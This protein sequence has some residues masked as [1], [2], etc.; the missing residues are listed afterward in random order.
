[1]HHTVLRRVRQDRGFTQ[2]ELAALLRRTQAS[3]AYYESG[4][5]RPDR[6]TRELLGKI[7]GRD[8]VELLAL[9][10]KNGADPK[11][12]AAQTTDSRQEVVR[13]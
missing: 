7:L 5:R 1:M 9:D 2:V 3:I 13:V 11:A 12:D 8:P 6:P 4:R 10:T